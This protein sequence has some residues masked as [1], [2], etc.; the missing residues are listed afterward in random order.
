MHVDNTQEYRTRNGDRVVIYDTVLRSSGGPIV[1]F[2]VKG[3]VIDKDHPRR[4][5]MQIWTLDGRADV[6]R[7]SR[8][9]VVGGFG[10][11]PQAIADLEAQRLQELDD[12]PQASAPGM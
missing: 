6:G 12:E 4:K 3:T 9:D 10:L 2:P 1:T 7:E 8:D 5:H 11:D